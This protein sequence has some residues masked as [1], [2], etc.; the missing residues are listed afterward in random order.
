MTARESCALAEDRLR[1][2]Q[3]LLR[4][5]SL[6]LC[7]QTLGQVIELLEEIAAPGHEHCEPAVHLALHRIRQSARDL[8]IQVDHG[9]RLVS[10]WMQ[11]RYS[12]GYTRR[13][14]P[15]FNECDSARNYEV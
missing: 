4:P 3:S 6:E 14:Q 8:Q 5:N 7:V 10:G 12:A 1:Q 15:A 9:S 2:A 13:G 11:V